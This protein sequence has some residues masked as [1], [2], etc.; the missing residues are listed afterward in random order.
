[1]LHC[2]LLYTVPVVDSIEVRS[3]AVSV[4]PAA[5]LCGRT[6]GLGHV[7]I[8]VNRRERHVVVPRHRVACIAAVN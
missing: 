1:M 2:S 5:M 8:R 6:V 3:G 4:P 7:V